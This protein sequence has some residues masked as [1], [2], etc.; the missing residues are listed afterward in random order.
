MDKVC[1]CSSCSQSALVKC[2]RCFSSLVFWICSSW[3]QHS[4][5]SN[6]VPWRALGSWHDFHRSH[7]LE[8]FR[9]YWP[10]SRLDKIQVWPCFILLQ[11]YLSINWIF[12]LI[13]VRCKMRVLD[14]F[15]T[16]ARYN[17]PGSGNDDTNYWGGLG[18]DL[19]QFMTMYR[20]CY[21]ERK[22]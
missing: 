9:G 1:S 10:V 3:F 8:G 6:N 12:F 17:Q 19:R 20:E 22:Q 2:S 7:R 5:R 4:V 21:I 11:R 16:E 15:G 18:Y 13:L 14:S